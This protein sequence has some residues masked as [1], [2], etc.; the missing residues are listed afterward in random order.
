[1]RLSDYNLFLLGD[2]SGG[3]DVQGRLAAGGNV[4]MTDF[5]VGTALANHDIANTLVAGN[6][7]HLSSGGVWGDAWYGNGYNADASVVYPR[8][9]VSQGSP[10]DFAARGTELRALSS[11]LAGL[12]G[13]GLTTLESWGG[14]M[15]LGTDPGVNVFEVDASA[16]TGAVLL[17]ISAPAGSLAVINITGDSATF[18]AFGHMF[19]GGIDQHGVLFNFVDATEIHANAYGFWGTVL[20][21]YAHVT[22]NDGSFDGGIYALSMTGN[23]EGHINALADRDICP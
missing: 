14:V 2:Y 19:S 9:G 15:L 20:A 22:F 3:Q 11:R 18:S 23:A 10:V 5:S 21:P 12:P 4:T 6:T 16:F 7:L 17:S 8:G 1:M 13:N